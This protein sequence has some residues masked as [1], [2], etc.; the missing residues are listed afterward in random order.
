MFWPFDLL[1][2]GNKQDEGSK[3]NI[4]QYIGKV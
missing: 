1:V 2:P 4:K 3:I